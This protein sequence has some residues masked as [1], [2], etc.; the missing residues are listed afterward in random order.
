MEVIICIV[1]LL[2]IILICGWV[3]DRDTEKFAEAEQKHLQAAAQF[4]ERLITPQTDWQL[5]PEDLFTISV[6][7][8]VPYI[9]YSSERL[10]SEYRQALLWGRQYI[11]IPIADFEEAK[12]KYTKKR[13]WEQDLA[14]TCC[15]NND[16][17]AF[18]KGGE[19]EEAIKVY[20]ENIELGF[21]AM[22]SYTRLMIIYRRLKDY[23]NEQRVIRRA[24]E[25][26]EKSELAADDVEKWKLRLEKSKLLQSKQTNKN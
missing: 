25:V 4:V 3:A 20:E 11:E 23:D 14:I 8:F 6:D 10:K 21:P 22:H 16:G 18:E 15:R 7:D 1:I 19:I 2:G 9:P 5:P 17:I 26:Y 13:L 24:I 12:D